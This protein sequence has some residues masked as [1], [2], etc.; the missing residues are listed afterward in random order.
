MLRSALFSSIARLRSR[1]A[2]VAAP[3]L[4]AASLL[5]ACSGPLDAYNRGIARLQY[6][7]ADELPSDQIN[8]IDGTYKGLT[9]LLASGSPNCPVPSTGTIDVGDK[10]VI[11][12]Y[13]PAVIFTA[14]VQPDGQ[15]HGVVGRV[16]M[17]GVVANG[18]LQ[19]VVSSPVCTSR[20]DFRY[21]I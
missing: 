17:D 9:S 13:T 18:L 6:G 20:Y 21:V 19:F 11:F 3:L 15:I 1:T 4:I 2:L 5:S 7:Q 8:R 16:R 12:A 10:T 14:P